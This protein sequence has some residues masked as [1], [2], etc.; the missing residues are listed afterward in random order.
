MNNCNMKVDAAALRR[1][2]AKTNVADYAG[3]TGFSRLSAS[4]KL[5]ALASMCVFVHECKGL[6]GAQ[7]G[8]EKDEG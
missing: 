3:E 4:Q 6:A 5:D 7:G 1:M 8:G 2:I